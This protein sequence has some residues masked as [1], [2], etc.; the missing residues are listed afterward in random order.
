M[1]L[2]TLRTL[3][4]LLAR[5]D[6][7]P[8]EERVTITGQDPVFPTRFRIGELGAAAIA[9]AALQAARIHEARGGPQQSISVAVD[10]AA[11][12]MRSWRYAQEVPAPPPAA[13]APLLGFY[14]ARDGR[15]IYMQRGLSHHLDREMRVLGIGEDR[16][17]EAIAAATRGWDALELEE[18]IVDAGASASVVRTRDEWALHPQARAIAGLPLFSITKTGESDPEPV[19][20]GDRPLGGVRVLDVTRV[21]AGPTAA[22]ALAEQGA[23][24]LRVSSPVY[25]EGTLMTRD[26]GHGKRSTV[27]DLRDDGA[28][29]A[30]DALVAKADV[31]SQGYRPGALERLGYGH[32]RLAALRP[33]II[34][35]SISAFGPAGPWRA[36]RGFDSVVQAASGAAWEERDDD[37]RP[38][39][40][41]ANP[42]DYTCG[43]LAAFA[44]EVA[45][46]RR[47]IEGG[48]YHI[49]LSL[50]QTGR[51]L[52]DLGLVS[53]EAARAQPGEL[54]DYRL[55]ELRMESDTGYGRL[56][57]LAPIA[58]LSHTPGRWDRPSEPPGQDR[59]IW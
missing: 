15:W 6:V 50:G 56:R 37:G 16:S 17:E 57:H 43:Y 19:G 31:F 5:A 42:L 41:P 29:A 49:E 10:A 21:L 20:R 13:P 59:P 22:R 39:S 33:G 11:A 44:V 35:V 25:P 45:L 32:E 2:R 26:T 53:R 40:T 28:R 38:L 47:S 12:A 9:A 48:S 14:P 52:D 34:S 46:T 55:D 51:Y 24:V 8:A 30:L 58:Q 3:D 1:T 36:R 4:D 27:L 7:A 18:A 54:P 23:D